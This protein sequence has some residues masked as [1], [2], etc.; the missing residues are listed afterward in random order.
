MPDRQCLIVKR[1]AIVASRS[2]LFI[3]HFDEIAGVVARP[4]DIG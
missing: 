2:F 1:H 4:W 3:G